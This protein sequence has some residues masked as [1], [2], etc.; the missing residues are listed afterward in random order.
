MTVSTRLNNIASIK[1]WSR[2]MIS[3]IVI[4]I[5]FNQLKIVLGR[6][7]SY[8]AF[9]SIFILSRYQRKKANSRKRKQTF[10]TEKK[11]AEKEIRKQA[12]HYS[13]LSRSISYVI[14]HL[15]HRLQGDNPNRRFIVVAPPQPGRGNRLSMHRLGLGADTTVHE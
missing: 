4:H 6:M 15:I 2:K 13:L 12:H 9:K 7:Q 8:F 1:Y 14:N 5:N 11:K 3:A 10:K